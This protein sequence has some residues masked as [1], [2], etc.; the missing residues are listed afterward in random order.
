MGNLLERYEIT[1]NR[2]AK[3]NAP[4]TSLIF[5]SLPFSKKV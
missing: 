1:A 3:S 5:K 4:L 2:V